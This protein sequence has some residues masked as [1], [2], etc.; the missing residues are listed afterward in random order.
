MTKGDYMTFKST[1]GLKSY[2]LSKMQPAISTTEEKIYQ[3][4]DKILAQ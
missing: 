3:V 1:D 4:I 2:L